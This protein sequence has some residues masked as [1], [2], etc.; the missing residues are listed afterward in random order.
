MSER[1]AQR[2]LLVAALAAL[3]GCGANPPEREWPISERWAVPDNASEAC[4]S[5]ARRASKFCLDKT[6]NSDIYGVY[7]SEC[8]KARWDHT[9]SCN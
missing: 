1:A 5:A 9:R 4:R 3:G 6:L 8:T 2:V 7:T